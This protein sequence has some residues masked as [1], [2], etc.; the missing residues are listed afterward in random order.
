[1][2]KT[3]QLFYLFLLSSFIVKLLIAITL[4]ITTDEAYFYIWGVA[5]DYGYYD[6]PPMVG[7]ML[8]LLQ[9]VSHDIGWLRF[10]SIL[11]TTFIGWLI[12]RIVAM[13]NEE[14]GLLAASL[15]VIMP[16]NLYGVLISTD[17]TLVLWMFLSVFTFYLAVEREQRAWF[18]LSG[19]FLGMAVLSKYFVALL[20]FSYLVYFLI[21]NR[22]KK[23]LVDLIIVYVMA[24]PAVILNLAWNYDHCWGNYMFNFVNRH[25]RST[26]LSFY[27]FVGYILMW[28]YLLVPPLFYYLLKK[29]KDLFQLK[30]SSERVFLV[31]FFVP[32]TLFFALSIVKVI[33]LHWVLGF[34]PFAFILAAFVLDKSQL[35]KS[36]KFAL[37]VSAAHLVVIGIVISKP[38]NFVE[39]GSR[40]YHEVVLGTQPERFLQEIEPY[41]N[42]FTLATVSYSVAAVMSYHARENVSVVGM[43]SSHARHDDIM[44]DFRTLDGKNI[45]VFYETK[46]RLEDLESFFDSFEYKEIV[47]EDAKFYVLLGQGFDYQ[48]YHTQY[49]ENIRDLYYQIPEV[50]PKGECYFYDR[51]F[52]EAS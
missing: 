49:L 40:Y 28:M 35:K 6:H 20:G 2:E 30:D 11:L 25:D 17:T 24:L 39:P 14:M 15:Y 26:G 31:T 45:L 52:P 12:Y 47:I 19:L 27:T 21:F 48:K 13:K 3:R 37:F 42:D 43:G 16:V 23:G 1:M 34:Y 8:W 10:P 18:V 46:S 33:G 32:V 51:Y 9:Q 50:L 41:R 4:P 7:W 44:T 38:L 5:P 29:R 22:N 36:I